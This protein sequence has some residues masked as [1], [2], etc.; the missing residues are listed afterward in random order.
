[1]DYEYS[2]VE[3]RDMHFC[4]GKAN[5][6][7]EKAR[8]FYIDT[9]PD[10]I[11]PHAQTFINVHRRL[12]EQGSFKNHNA[13]KGRPRTTRTV[14]IEERILDTVEVNPPSKHFL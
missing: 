8:R 4:Y 14:E 10:R 1:M 13:D 12:G 6:N 7:A 3:Y 11:A 9:Y 2:S 5:G